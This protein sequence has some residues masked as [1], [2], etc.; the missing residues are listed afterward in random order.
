MYI[1]PFEHFLSPIFFD[2]NSIIR[3]KRKAIV[4]F[5]LGQFE[6]LHLNK[7]DLLALFDDLLVE[8]K[9]N[10]HLFIFNN[11]N[12]K[13]FIGNGSTDRLDAVIQSMKKKDCDL[14]FSG[15]LKDRV[16]ATYKENL[17]SRS[18]HTFIQPYTRIQL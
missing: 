17:T 3:S 11:A 18:Y 13:S 10:T 9:Y 1:S 4:D 15:L 7:N 12:L 5:E 2:R 16:I 8:A 6:H 14:F